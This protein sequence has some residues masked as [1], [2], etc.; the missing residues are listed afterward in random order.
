M[1]KTEQ[2]L[3]LMAS[4]G[5][6]PKLGGGWG[7]GVLGWMIAQTHFRSRTSEDASISRD[8]VDGNLLCSKRD[9]AATHAP[10]CIW[11]TFCCVKNGKQTSAL[12][13]RV[14]AF[15]RANEPAQSGLIPT[16][17]EQMRGFSQRLRVRWEDICSRRW[18]VDPK[19]VRRAPAPETLMHRLGGLA[20]P[21]VLSLLC[22]L[23]T[24]RRETGQTSYRQY[25]NTATLNG[26]MNTSQ[27]GTSEWSLKS[28]GNIWK[29][30]S[31]IC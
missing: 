14:G 17:N 30:S 24:Y 11:T 16:T 1:R 8:C 7:G 26:R 29:R 9:A 31:N 19:T 10:S 18:C 12:N 3:G 5:K 28:S 2:P 13:T 6:A 22:I 27:P 15:K 21:Q 20:L 4:K 23:R 25:L